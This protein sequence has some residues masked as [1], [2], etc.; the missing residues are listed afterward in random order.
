VPVVG[1]LVAAAMIHYQIRPLSLPAIP[2]NPFKRRASA[3]QPG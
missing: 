2:L 3:E 1:I